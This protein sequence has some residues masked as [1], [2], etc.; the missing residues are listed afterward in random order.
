MTD[1]AQRVLP[2]ASWAWLHSTRFDISFILG[3]PLAAFL[4]GIIVVN[5]PQWFVPILIVDLWLLGYHHVVA[6]Y[7]RL[8]FDGGAFLSIGD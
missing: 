8:C 7:T 1:V 5:N 6:T 2:N 3:V 4:T